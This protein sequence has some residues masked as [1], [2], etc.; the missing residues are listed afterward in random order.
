MQRSAPVRS[1][2]VV[3]RRRRRRRR[4][5]S[6][7]ACDARRRRQ[8]RP[9]PS[10][11]RRRSAPPS[12]AGDARQRPDRARHLQA[13]RA[14]RRLRPR[15]RS[16]SRRSRRSTSA[17]PRS[18]GRGH[19]LGLRDRQRRAHPHQRPRR[20]RRAEGH[21]SS[22]QTSRRVDAKV[23]GKDD[24][25]RP[26]AAEGRPRRASTLT[27]L[28]A[29]RLVARR[30]GRRPGDRD[31]QPVRPRPHA[32]H[33]RRLRPA[34]QDPG[35]QRLHDRRRHPDRRARSTP[36]T[37]AARCIDAAG[38]VIGD[39]LAD[40][41]R[42]QRQ[43]RQRRHRLRRADRH[44][45]ADPARSSRS[46][47]RVER[48]LPRH[49]R[50]DDRQV[51]RRP[52][53]ARRPRR[54]GAVGHARQPGRRRRA[55][56]AATSPAHA[57]RPADPARRRH[58]HQG[59]R[60]AT[61]R[62]TDD[63]VTAVAASK[64]G[65]KV[66]VTLLRGGKIADRHGHAR[67][68]PATRDQAAAADYARAGRLR[69]ARGPSHVKI[70]GITTLDD[71]ALAVDAG[72]LGGRHASSGRGS[73]RACDPAEAAR[74]RRRAAPA[75]RGRRRVRQRARSTRSPGWSTASGSRCVQLH[76][77]EGPAFC[78]RGRAPHRAPR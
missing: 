46:P 37:P 35:A 77:D 13:R 10:S 51:A 44:R 18:S 78:A 45:Q 3:G 16:S 43:R 63:V 53:P 24:V 75:R 33:R 4:S 28:D 52:Q 70:C 47:A 73:P 48:A 30:A 1:P 59:R 76:G 5:A 6:S 65:D 62:T 21:A 39:Q 20:R 25:D 74:D 49:H 60:Q 68:A 72:R 2:L 58:H 69:W 32:D 41:D 38:R 54:A 15:R 61:S 9:R 22:S 55:S 71:A 50:R 8:R 67:R 14:G 57:R 17:C 11:S 64:P 56:T 40:R 19:R 36:A 34:A 42:R 12:D 27:P 7:R 26:R 66:K 29:R 31:R 23:V